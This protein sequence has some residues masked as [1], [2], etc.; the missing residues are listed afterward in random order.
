RLEDLQKLIA[1][2]RAIKP[3]YT[4]IFKLYYTDA[5]TVQSQI[6]SVLSGQPAS[7]SGNQSQG[8][9][10]SGITIDKRINSLIVKKTK[11]EIDLIA[12]LIAQ[13]DVRTPQILIEAFIVQASN[14]FRK[15]LGA[16]LGYD[17]QD[18]WESDSGKSFGVSG[19]ATGTAGPQSLGATAGT[20]AENLLVSGVTG[21]I[22]GL[23]TAGATTLKLELN[24]MEQDGYT[25]ILSNPRVYVLNNEQAVI[26]QGFEIPFETSSGDASGG[27]D[28]EFKDAKLVLTVTPSIVGDGNIRLDIKIEKE[29]ADLTQP[30]PP[31]RSEEI[32]TKLMVRDGT[33]VVIGG[34]KSRN[35][36]DSTDKVPFF[37]DLPFI[38]YLFRHTADTD[39]L[40]EMLVFIAPR[41]I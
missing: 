13:I 25:K 15:E 10:S 38:G 18:L 14:D 26:K 12:R 3:L 24:A 5:K 33:I 9:G 1:A 36:T 39:D 20:I 16:R 29:D 19:L 4:E 37:G 7:S 21:G 23:F 2:Q 31:I 30:N 8:G 27:T 34:V 40:D 6:E 32:T 22:G 35:T 11:S 17:N 41:I 28:I